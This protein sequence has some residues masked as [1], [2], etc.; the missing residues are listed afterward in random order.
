MEALQVSESS[1]GGMQ[2]IER[3]RLLGITDAVG[4]RE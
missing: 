2:I 3:W 1:P 4:K